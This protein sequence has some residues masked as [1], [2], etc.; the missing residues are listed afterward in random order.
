VSRNQEDCLKEKI[1]RND[2]LVLARLL[3][4]RAPGG[5]FLSSV[6]PGSQGVKIKRVRD[7]GIK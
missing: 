6:I 2:W 7:T 1:Y 5:L 4:L 3:F